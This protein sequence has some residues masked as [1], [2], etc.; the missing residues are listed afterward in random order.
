MTRGRFIDH[1]RSTAFAGGMP[2]GRRQHFWA[3]GWLGICI[4]APGLLLLSIWMPVA[5]HYW[6]P[7][8]TVDDAT[9]AMLRTAP[10]SPRLQQIDQ[11]ARALR[12]ALSDE[13]A[14]QQLPAIQSGR[15]ILASG[16]PRR[17]SRP[18]T[19]EDLEDGTPGG[20]LAVAS[21]AIADT[22]LQGY[23]LTGQA[24]HLSMARDVILEFAEI[25]RGL[26]ADRGLIRNDHAIAA[27]VGVLVRF[28]RLYRTHP[29]F[30]PAVARVLLQHL[31]RCAAYLAKRSHHTVMTNHGVMQNVALLQAAAA[32]PLPDAKRWA[33]TAR[34]RLALQM[35]FFVSSEGLVLEHSPQYHRFGLDLMQR[36]AQGL[37]WNALPP[38]G[39]LDR[40]LAPARA[41]LER[42][43]QP[44][45]SLPRI[46]DTGTDTRAKRE[47]AARDGRSAD[48]VGV[49]LPDGSMVFP[50]AGY[51]IHRRPSA[52]REGKGADSQLT[53]YWGYFARHGHEVAAEGSVV[54]WAAGRSW[55]A[56]TGYW[57]YG[58]AG[59]ADSEGWRGSNAPHLRGETPTFDRP[60]SL[61]AY[62]ADRDALLL[63][64]HRR[65]LGGQMLARE[66]VAIDDH[67]WAVLD[68]LQGDAGVPVDR[69]WT[70]DPGLRVQSDGQRISAV[71]PITGWSLVVDLLGPQP[72][73]HQVLRASLAPFGGW[74][75]LDGKPAPATS[76]EVTQPVGTS[77]TAAVMQLVEPGAQPAPRP[78]LRW[79]RPQAW[80]LRLAGTQGEVHEA[81]RADRTLSI[82]SAG[83]LGRSFMIEPMSASVEMERA[84]LRGA[85]DAA[86]NAYPRFRS[87]IPYRQR[88]TGAVAGLALLSLAVVALTARWRRRTLGWVVMAVVLGWSLVALWVHMHYLV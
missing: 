20:A 19:I 62:G 43:E 67:R 49:G 86:L 1:S 81:R 15:I 83:Y 10:P 75:V 78:Q 42:L 87:Y 29:S 51:A 5:L 27:R 41:A 68:H 70:F 55:I 9:V 71:D 33:Q 50:V 31:S 12:S 28:W 45:G 79:D 34:E 38:V 47:P 66:V 65:T 60:Q 57:P 26:F 6:V 76:V 54:L 36:A 23:E 22:L 32:F 84:R 17:F 82:E 88:L 7:S 40:A 44:D 59:R 4:A 63:E 56:N 18:L 11:Q 39:D 46:G 64:L 69:L 2:S 14:L 30:D 73:A 35:T 8:P 48:V 25:E 53:T 72:V 80:V 13:S 74:A 37:Q 77:W 58:A 3:R 24:V 21:L 85:A 61:A 16:E 52:Q